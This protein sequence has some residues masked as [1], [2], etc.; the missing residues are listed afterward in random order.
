LNLHHGSSID[1]PWLPLKLP[2]SPLPQIQ[3]RLGGVIGTLQPLSTRHESRH[4]VV[5]VTVEVLSS[6]VV[7]RRRPGIGVAGGNL[8]ISQRRVRPL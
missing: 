2:R 8:D 4:D 6:P 5:G 3:R 7:D 1:Q